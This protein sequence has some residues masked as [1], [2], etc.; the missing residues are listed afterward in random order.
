MATRLLGTTQQRMFLLTLLGN[1]MSLIFNKTL[2]IDSGLSLERPVDLI[3]MPLE[4]GQSMASNVAI[5]PT[6]INY[7]IHSLHRPS[8]FGR[9][10]NKDD[11]ITE[12]LFSI[13]TLRDF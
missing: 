7:S 1:V 2:N 6:G 11:S 5:V 4:S 9:K 13:S 8:V 12:G 10:F 3:D